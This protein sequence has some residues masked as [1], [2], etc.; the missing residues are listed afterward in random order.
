MSI[1]CAQQEGIP[2][3]GVYSYNKD[4][5]DHV[6]AS[7]LLHG[8]SSVIPLEDGPFKFACFGKSL[9]SAL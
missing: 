7:L 5:N 4:K 1:K 9:S 2:V 8:R 3:L 6:R